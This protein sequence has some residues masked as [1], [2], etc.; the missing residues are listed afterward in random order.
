MPDWK[1]L[2]PELDWISDPSLRDKVE[3]TWNEACARGGWGDD[4][5]ES[6]PFTMLV[7]TGGVSLIDHTRLVTRICRRAAEAIAEMGTVP[8][9]RDT[10]MAGALLHDVGKL[11][12]YRAEKG[13]FAVSKTGKLLRHPISGLGLAMR[14]DLPEE[15]CHIIAVH[16][17]EGEGSYRSPEAIV[18]HH[19]DFI[20]FE[21]IK[22]MKDAPR[23]GG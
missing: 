3:R 9:D 6:I 16:S 20:A 12:E 11:L 22:A 18:L 2:F 17:R 23:A 7:A 5:I 8:L 4:E 19:A 15:V 21:T 10:L 1:S 14:N 13:A